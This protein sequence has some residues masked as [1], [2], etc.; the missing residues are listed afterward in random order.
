MSP[1][2]LVLAIA[3]L[4]AVAISPS[5]VVGAAPRPFKAELTGNAHLS[6]TDDPFVLRN[7]ETGQG[8]ATHLG[9]FTWADVEFADFA[10]VPG[11]VAVIGM[12]TMTAAN[13]DRLYGTFT[14]EG[15]FAD[16]STLVIHGEFE[17]IGGTG[18]FAGATGGGEIDAVGS[19][20]PG[21]PFAGTI[22]GTIVY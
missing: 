17:F 14:S 6:P 2:P 21:L 1:K 8:Q 11:G 20:A 22:D 5:P 4:C 13:G 15:V 9:R 18:R 3:A 12:F 19:L 10:A 7:D 16:P